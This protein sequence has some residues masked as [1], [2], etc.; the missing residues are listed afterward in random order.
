MASRNTPPTHSGKCS[1]KGSVKENVPQSL[2]AAVATTATAAVPSAT[3]A[4]SSAK[5]VTNAIPPIEK[6]QPG[7]SLRRAP[8]TS[9]SSSS[10]LSVVIEERL[11]DRDSIEL[12]FKKFD[13]MRSRVEA[14]ERFNDMNLRVTAGLVVAGAVAIGLALCSLLKK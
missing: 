1:M 7:A 13:E 5:T 6:I 14:I 2:D 3:T 12:F 9:S 10:Q 11:D 8:V 4:A